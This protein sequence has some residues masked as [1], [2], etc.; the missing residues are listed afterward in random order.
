MRYG[1]II[2]KSAKIMTKSK[3]L[4]SCNYDKFEIMRKMS[5]I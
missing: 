5:K 3:M 2:M 4:I 1:V